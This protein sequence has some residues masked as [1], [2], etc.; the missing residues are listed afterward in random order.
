M[1]YYRV[2]PYNQYYSAFLRL[3]ITLLTATVLR[4]GF[5][6]KFTTLVLAMLPANISEPVGVGL[7][8]NYITTIAIIIM[9]KISQH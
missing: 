6:Y 1:W 8:Y 7:G 4:T 2:I 5:A 9:T 3:S